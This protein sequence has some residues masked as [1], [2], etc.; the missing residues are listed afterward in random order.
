MLHCQLQ[1]TSDENTKKELQEEIIITEAKKE[2]AN[3]RYVSF[4]YHVHL[5][6][7]MLRLHIDY[8]ESSFVP[9]I[10]YSWDIHILNKLLTYCQT[11]CNSLF[12]ILML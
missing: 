10:F 7:Q 3:L 6:V 4:Y 9:Y 2:L 8:S 5:F 11:A 1:E 12:S